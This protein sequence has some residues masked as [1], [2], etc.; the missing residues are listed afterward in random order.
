MTAQEQL[1]EIAKATPPVAVT[2]MKFAG[3]QVSDILIILTIVYTV[4]QT[5]YIV[6]RFFQSRHVTDV[7]CIKD[8]PNRKRL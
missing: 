8:C 5:L 3:V 4:L 2:T 7:T 1:A 6:W